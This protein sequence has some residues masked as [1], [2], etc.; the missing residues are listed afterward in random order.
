MVRKTR[1]V[2]SKRVRSR[3]VRK[4]RKVMYGGA[5]GADRSWHGDDGDEHKLLVLHA[6]TEMV[7]HTR[8]V[9]SI[10]E[11]G[12][13]AKAKLKRLAEAFVNYPYFFFAKDSGPEVNWLELVDH[14]SILIML[15]YVCALCKIANWRP[16]EMA[17]LIEQGY[18]YD[19]QFIVDYVKTNFPFDIAAHP[20]ANRQGVPIAPLCD[21]CNH[22]HFL[23]KAPCLYCGHIGSA[24]EII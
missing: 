1:R 4:S 20:A 10:V 14:E 21:I 7:E 9:K 8:E 15:P 17:K 3:K 13:K 11:E 16:S 6:V 2:R 24:A 23:N 5:D 18:T 12:G 19:D 22:H